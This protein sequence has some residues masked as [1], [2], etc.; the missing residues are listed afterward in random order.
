MHTSYDPAL[1]ILSGYGVFLTK[2][3]SFKSQDSLDIS[4]FSVILSVTFLAGA[5]EMLV[6]LHRV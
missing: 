6:R 4:V 1:L 3:E 5:E 2:C